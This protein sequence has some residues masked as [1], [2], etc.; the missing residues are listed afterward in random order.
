MPLAQVIGLRAFHVTSGPMP[1]SH[2]HPELEFN[3]VLSGSARYATAAG[4]VD[5]PRGRLAVFWGGY[6]HRLVSE[7]DVDLLWVT[8]PLSAVIG[9]PI[10]Q[11]AVD[12]LLRGH[13]LY[14]AARE[15]AHDRFLMRRWEQELRLGR[16]PADEAEIC[17]LE[18]H[19]RLARL[20]NGRRPATAAV[21]AR[22]AERMLAV[23]ARGYTGDLSVEEI[24]DAAG[25]H[26]TYAALAFKQALGMS[27]WQYVTQLRLAHA[28]RLL[29]GTDW[30]VDRI[31]HASG[32]QTRSSFYRAFRRAHGQSPGEYRSA[33]GGVSSE[34]T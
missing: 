26:P 6:P 12:R 10:L 33:G 16:S 14:G 29:S 32:F 2:I 4:E 7:R 19:A 24:A 28:R 30:G 5:L 25:A 31:A 9:R 13:F 34:A 1:R 11:D 27:V 17:L 23:I 3:L 20:A 22:S 18:L 15:A 21:E 8:V